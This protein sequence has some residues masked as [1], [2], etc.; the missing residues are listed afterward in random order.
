M[1]NTEYSTAQKNIN[2]FMFAYLDT[3]PLRHNKNS[4]LKLFEQYDTK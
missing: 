3:F 1:E 4:I 2:H